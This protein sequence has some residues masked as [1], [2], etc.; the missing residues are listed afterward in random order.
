MLVVGD[1]YLTSVDVDNRE[2]TDFVKYICPLWFAVTQVLYAPDADALTQ[3]I[4][5]RPFA[6][7]GPSSA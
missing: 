1:Q 7:G 2:E 6:V 4:K 5:P 3:Q